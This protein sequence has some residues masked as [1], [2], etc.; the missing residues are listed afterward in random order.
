MMYCRER[1]STVRIYENPRDGAENVTVRPVLHLSH[2]ASPD[3]KGNRH[4]LASVSY[5]RMHVLIPLGTVLRRCRQSLEPTTHDHIGTINFIKDHSPV[6]SLEEE[7]L[8]RE[9]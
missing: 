5:H 4:G 7:S 2:P 8:L 9:V 1:P 3:E 6:D